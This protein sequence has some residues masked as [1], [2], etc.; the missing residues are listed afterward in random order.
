M[1]KPPKNFHVNNI[2]MKIIDPLDPAI[3]LMYFGL[4]GLIRAADARM[5]QNGLGRAHHRILYV[6]AR[7]DGLTVGQLGEQLGISPQALHGPLK[8]L[9]ES[10]YVAESRRADRHRYKSL[11]LTQVGRTLEEESTELERAVMRAAFDEVGPDVAAKWTQV[12]A[13]IAKHA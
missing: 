2:D 3:E 12:M 8:K 7:M 6:L 11:H 1:T 5:A 4:K 13:L 10:G 9:R